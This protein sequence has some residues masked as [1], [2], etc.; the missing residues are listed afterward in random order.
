[1]RCVAAFLLDAARSDGL[2]IPALQGADGDA[3]E[4]QTGAAVPRTVN[5]VLTVCVSPGGKRITPR[6]TPDSA[7]TT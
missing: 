4:D 3:F 7:L 5:C 2:V 1:M 6:G